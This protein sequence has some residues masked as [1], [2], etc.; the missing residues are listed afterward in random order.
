MRERGR[1]EEVKE[2]SEREKDNGRHE[3]GKERRKDVRKRI[4]RTRGGGGKDGG[5]DRI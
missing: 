3:G 1:G 4:R 2:I 5:R